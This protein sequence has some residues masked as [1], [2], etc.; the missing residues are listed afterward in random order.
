MSVHRKCN[1]CVSVTSALLHT[2][3]L[4]PTSTTSS[5]GLSKPNSLPLSIPRFNPFLSLPP[6]PAHCVIALYVIVT[7]SPLPFSLFISFPFLLLPG[8]SSSPSNIYEA[9][10]FCR[11]KGERC[12]SSNIRIPPLPLHRCHGNP[13][14][15]QPTFGFVI[16]DLDCVLPLF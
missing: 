12:S 11:K 15:P 13:I 6:P 16:N 9:W 4:L 3:M 10:W 5:L 7:T 2:R 14:I 1:N 8:L